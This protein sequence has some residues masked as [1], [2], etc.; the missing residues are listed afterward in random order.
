MK[1][2]FGLSIPQTLEEVCDPQRVALLVYDMQIGILSQIKN[3]GV[4]TRQVSK[5]LTAARAAGVRVFFSRHLSLPKE[6]M[7]MF[8]FRMAMAWQRVDSP[9]QVNPW[10]LRDA[11]GF[12]IV[13]ELSPLPTEGVFDKLT[14]SAFEGTWLDFALRDCGINSFI[15]VGVATEIGIEPT[16]RHGADLGYIPVLVTDACGAGNEEAAKRSIENLKFTGD[17]LITD[18]EEICQILRK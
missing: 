16:A 1:N 5:V 8:Q 7:G 12:Q 14:M 9:D 2:I 15:V 13:P 17:A 3:G 18:T 10:F 6:L 4:V 11:P